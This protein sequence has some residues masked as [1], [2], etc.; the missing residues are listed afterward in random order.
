MNRLSVK[1]GYWSA[2]ILTVILIAGYIFGS[3]FT[4]LFVEIPQWTNIIDFVAAIQPAFL[5]YPTIAQ[6]AAFLGLPLLLIIFFCLH[7][8][9]SGDKKILTRIGLCFAAMMVVSGCV[10]YFVHFN[11][12]R[13]INA[14]ADL[15]GC[16]A[17]VSLHPV[18]NGPRTQRQVAS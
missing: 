7:E 3:A 14:N 9:V 13:L 17:C 18:S 6:V 1:L 15:A 12:V 10:Y 16:A 2:I 8:Y 5:V 4:L 11:G